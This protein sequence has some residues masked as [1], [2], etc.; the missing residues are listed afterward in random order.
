MIFGCIGDCGKSEWVLEV[1]AV[2]YTLVAPPPVRSRP[3]RSKHHG[4]DNRRG[5]NT[6]LITTRLVTPKGSADNIGQ[7]TTNYASYG[8]DV[9]QHSRNYGL[10]SPYT[11]QH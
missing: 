1:Q 11:R 10:H 4:E 2:H 8:P 7:H 3:W 9:G 5:N 6:T